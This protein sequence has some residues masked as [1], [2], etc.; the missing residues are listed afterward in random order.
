LNLG[1]C[2]DYFTPYAEVHGNQANFIPAGGN[3]DTG[4]YYISNKGCQVPRSDGFNALLT[5]SNINEH[6][7]TRQA[8]LR[9]CDRYS[10]DY[11]GALKAQTGRDTRA[12]PTTR[13]R[14]WDYAIAL[15]ACGIFAILALRAKRPPLPMHMFWANGLLVLVLLTFLGAGWWLWRK[16]RFC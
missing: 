10:L 16:T 11:L 3:G 14:W 12:V 9:E 1:L 5:S 6:S 2:W 8:I 13:R 7:S 4:A 15:V